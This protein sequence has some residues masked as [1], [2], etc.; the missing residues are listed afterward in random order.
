MVP[1]ATQLTALQ[2]V[3]GPSVPTLVQ[4]AC[5]SLVPLC[6]CRAE[7]SDAAREKFFVPESDHLTLLHV[8]QQW[9][10]NGYRADW[11]NQHF[12]Q[13]GQPIY[14]I[15][16]AAYSCAARAGATS[17]SCRWGS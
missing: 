6:L 9:K 3:W 14:S 10:T 8:Y 7:E 16:F 5:A 15:A 2:H 13:V 11:C 1:C 12:L 4:F 17:T